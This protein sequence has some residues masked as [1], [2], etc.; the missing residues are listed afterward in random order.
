MNREDDLRWCLEPLFTYFPKRQLFNNLLLVAGFIPMCLEDF[1]PT[2]KSVLLSLGCFFLNML[3]RFTGKGR[4]HLYWV[5]LLI[6]GVAVPGHLLDEA[7]CT[8][9]CRHQLLRCYYCN[10]P[11]W[12][13]GRG[14]MFVLYLSQPVLPSLINSVH[15]RDAPRKSCLPRR[16]GE[17]STWKCSS[18][19]EHMG[20]NS[21][22]RHLW[23]DVVYFGVRNSLR[24]WPELTKFSLLMCMLSCSATKILM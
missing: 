21:T 5:P 9:V 4:Y 17:R 12:G 18:T 11:S 23:L 22:C 16:K 15:Y 19:E 13:R 24:S 1:L 20:Y 10:C 8:T 3:F 6:E 7:V 14:A 2:K